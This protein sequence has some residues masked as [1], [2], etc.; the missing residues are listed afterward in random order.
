[1]NTVVVNGLTTYPLEDV[2]LRARHQAGNKGS[3]AKQAETILIRADL[4]AQLQA[5]EAATTLEPV[6]PAFDGKTTKVREYDPETLTKEE[7]EFE[8]SCRRA[9]WFYGYS[10]DIRVYKAGKVHCDSLVATS[11]RLGG[12][13]LQILKFYN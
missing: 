11:K 2:L 4:I 6:V 13:Y 3:L 7:K 9:D 10:D 8:D 12:V 5:A 1:M